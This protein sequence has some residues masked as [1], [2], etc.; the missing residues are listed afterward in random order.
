MD[1]ALAGRM[2][3]KGASDFGASYRLSTSAGPRLPFPEGVVAEK[4]EVEVDEVDE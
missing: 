2:G 3:F 1:F 4:V